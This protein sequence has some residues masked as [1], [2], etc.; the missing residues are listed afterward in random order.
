MFSAE[1]EKMH[2]IQR[3]AVPLHGAHRNMHCHLLAAVVYMGELVWEITSAKAKRLLWP[4]SSWGL[5]NQQFSS[6]VGFFHFVLHFFQYLLKIRK[7][8]RGRQTCMAVAH[9]LI[10]LIWHSLKSYGYV[11]LLSPAS[12]NCISCS[13]FLLYCIVLPFGLIINSSV[14]GSMQFCCHSS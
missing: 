2:K 11:C 6:L 8:K 9:V 13:R 1:H 3:E 12:S 5:V 14:W 10:P 4:Q 7:K